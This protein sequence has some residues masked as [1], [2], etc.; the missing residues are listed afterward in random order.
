MENFK[1]QLDTSD[2]QNLESAKSAALL[3]HDELK[4]FRK[5][6]EKEQKKQQEDRLKK[7]EELQNK[8]RKAVEEATKT[9][10]V[11]EAKKLKAAFDK[12]AEELKQLI[13]ETEKLEEIFLY[14]PTK[15]MSAK[16]LEAEMDK[17]G[18]R[19]SSLKELSNI[20]KEKLEELINLLKST[21]KLY[22]PS[23]EKPNKIEPFSFVI[24]KSH[25]EVINAE[26]KELRP[27]HGRTI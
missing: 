24:K 19:P 14:Q 16:E 2:T 21:E 5:L 7:L 20:S 4:K 8:F 17:Q 22:N 26:S 25:Q 15:P 18:F 13:A 10:S 9:G 11:E 27:R 23:K 12:D 6:P 3:S 1:P